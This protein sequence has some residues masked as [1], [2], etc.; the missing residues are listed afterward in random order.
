[1]GR[2]VGV[3][4]SD[5]GSFAGHVRVVPPRWAGR[6]AQRVDRP[7]MGRRRA[8]PIRS[9]PVAPKSDF[10]VVGRRPRGSTG[11]LKG[12]RSARKIQGHNLRPAS[13]NHHHWKILSPAAKRRAVDMLKD[14][15]GISERLAC[16]AV[17]L[18]RSTYQRVPLAASPADPD[19][20][21]RA[22]LR[23]YAK[24]HPCHGFVGPGRRCATTSTAGSTRRG[25][26]A[27][28]R[29]G[30]AARVHSRRKTRRGVLAPAGL[31][32]CSQRWSGRWTSSSTP[33][34]TAGPSRSPRW[35]MSTPASRC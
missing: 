17:G 24:A 27:V 29:G 14:V 12:T 30:P 16:K 2:G 31:R 10:L 13:R 35:S 32:G 23:A 9:H 34:S 11:P 18:A 28:G 3:N 1:M 5:N 22:W 4:S 19:A 25:A 7:V 33:P 8:R 26:A 15:K 20:D 21:L 6:R